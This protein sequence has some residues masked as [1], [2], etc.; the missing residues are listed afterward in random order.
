METEKTKNKKI[1]KTKRSQQALEKE[2]SGKSKGFV[3]EIS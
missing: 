3:K 2:S 1:R